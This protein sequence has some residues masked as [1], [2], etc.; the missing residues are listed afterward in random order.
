MECTP[1]TV[2]DTIEQHVK[3]K[4]P[5]VEVTEEDL[6]NVKFFPYNNC[7]LYVHSVRGKRFAINFA[8]RYTAAY[9]TKF[10]NNKVR[11]GY[12]SHIDRDQFTAQVLK[13]LGLQYV[14]G[15]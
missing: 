10:Y 6:R 1:G 8:D 15:A 11:K 2:S 4:Y 13:P 7:F 3:L 14:S 9:V 12:A 5:D